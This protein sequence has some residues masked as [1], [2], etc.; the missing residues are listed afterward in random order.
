[1]SR[2]YTLQFF[3]NKTSDAKIHGNEILIHKVAFHSWIL[4]KNR[5]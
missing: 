1:M 2:Y 5:I 3:R 4:D